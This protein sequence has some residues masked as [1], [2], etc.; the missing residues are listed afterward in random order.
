MVKPNLNRGRKK[1]TE[2][3]NQGV[4]VRLHKKVKEKR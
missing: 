2:E 3:L 4:P 1:K